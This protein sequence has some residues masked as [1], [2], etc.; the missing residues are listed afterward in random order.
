MAALGF[1]FDAGSVTPAGVYEVLPAGDYEVMIVDSTL[2]PT[3]SG[4]GSFLKL[5]MQV[6]SGPHKDATIF[7]RLNLVN[8]NPKAVEIAQRTLSAICHAIGVM[9]VADSTQLHNRPMIVRLTVKPAEGQYG[10]SNECKGYKPTSAGITQAPAATATPIAAQPAQ[11]QAAAY[12]A[13]FAP[14]AA[15]APAGGPPWMSQAA[16]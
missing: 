6:L 9:Q 3:K 7:D 1:S 12:N 13:P 4:S 14:P 11:P 8:D 2:E 15:Q 5:Q 16:A 10:P